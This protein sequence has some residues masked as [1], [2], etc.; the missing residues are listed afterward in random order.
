M[1][2]RSNSENHIITAIALGLHT[3]SDAIVNS[4]AFDLQGADS[5]EITVIAGAWDA[6]DTI[7]GSQ[8]EIGLQHS[9]DTVSGNFVDVPDDLLSNTISG[10]STVSGGQASGVF[11]EVTAA[12][13]SKTVAT[14]YLGN[15]R[16]LRT[17]TNTQE[18]VSNGVPLTTI[19]IKGHLNRKPA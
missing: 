17:V 9:D 5:A 16:Y 3:G 18:N 4:A 15:K 10:D 7:A 6:G 19:L 2:N 1:P 11:A 12:S 14:D 13:D 8:V